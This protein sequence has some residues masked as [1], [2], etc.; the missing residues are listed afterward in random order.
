MMK[1]ITTSIRDTHDYEVSAGDTGYKKGE[2]ITFPTE[3]EY[4]RWHRRGACESAVD[5]AAR[6]KAEKIKKDADDKA[7]RGE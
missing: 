7:A 6:L 3:G 2:T 4:E 1:Y 5:N